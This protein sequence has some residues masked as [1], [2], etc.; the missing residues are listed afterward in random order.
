MKKLSILLIT[1][2]LF[3]FSGIL[4]AS[5][6]Y[7]AENDIKA[8][9]VQILVDSVI[10]DE[11]EHGGVF[12]S[13]SSID[14]GSYAEEFDFKFIIHN[15]NIIDDIEH[16]F[17]VSESNNII[18]VFEWEGLSD[19]YIDANGKL[20]EIGSIPSQAPVKP[21]LTHTG[22]KNYSVDYPN[23]KV[24]T[25]EASDTAVTVSVTG[26]TA[27]PEH[28]TY[29]QIV[30]LDRKSTRLNSSHVRISYAV[31]CLKKKNR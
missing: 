11:I 9:E 20:L 19:I 7:A 15:D 24:A 3:I 21:G 13:K 1:L 30:T 31:F 23:V 22:Y 28:P 10:M 2:S 27:D 16:N 5:E 18:A 6:V 14:F 26:G 17:F 12:G 8:V 4:F 29:N 25:Y